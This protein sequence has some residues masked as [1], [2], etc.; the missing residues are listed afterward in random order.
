MPIMPMG[1][2]LCIDVITAII[3][4]GIFAIGVRYKHIKN[5]EKAQKG[6]FSSIVEGLKYVKNNKFI[7]RFLCYYAV[8]TILIAPIGILTPLMVTR[9]FG[10]E[11]WR[12]TLNE[13]VFFIGSILGGSIISIWGGF[14]N[15]IYTLALGCFLC[16]VFGV[17]MGIIT[18]ANMFIIYLIIMGLMGVLMPMFNTPA[19]VILQEAVEKDMYGRVFSIV[20]II[21]S[22]IMPLSMILFGPLSDIID[23]EIILIVSSILFMIAPLAVIKDKTIKNIPMI[24]KES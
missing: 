20:N 4:V 19:I 15:K 2:I 23:I 24:N 14:K 16:G 6:Y 10:D 22:G 17:A 9:T 18:F 12:L 7:K 3:G 11:A 1:Y 21:A 5:E 13:I 8:I